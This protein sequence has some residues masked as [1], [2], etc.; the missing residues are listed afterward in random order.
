[1]RKV[2]VLSTMILA[3]VGVAFADSNN[4][5]DDVTGEVF[6]AKL[7]GMA[8]VP[9]NFTPGT[10]EMKIAVDESR[11]TMTV[12]VEFMNLSSPSTAVQLHLGGTSENGPAVLT[13]CG[14]NSGRLCPS[15]EAVFTFGL[16]GA[17]VP[18]GAPYFFD[19]TASTL[20]RGLRAGALHV[21]LN[22]QAL[23]AGEIRGQVRT[24]DDGADD[25]GRGRGRDDGPGDD[26]GG[27]SGNRG[28]GNGG[29]GQDDS[30][31][32]GNDKGGRRK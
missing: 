15:R 6:K 4:G 18:Q 19:A 10:G 8:S 11:G 2:A 14:M 13:V 12:K 32:G 7:S 25:R 16:A 17:L 22:T 5:L 27:D 20:L 30:P 21:K 31:S 9:A 1:M 3:A 24:D 26:R 23:P 29:N 28:G